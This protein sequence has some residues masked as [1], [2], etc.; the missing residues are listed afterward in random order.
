M[1]EVFMEELIYL[2]ACYGLTFTICDAKLFSRPREW[3]K[4]K[5]RLFDD[6]LTCYFCVGFWCSIVVFVVMHY[7]GLQ[8]G[9][10]WLTTAYVITYGFAGATFAYALNAVIVLMEVT[11]LPKMT[12]TG[13][14]DNLD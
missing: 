1:R 4:S 12:I 5:A 2:L 8:D 10:W 6:L 13:K 7:G 3:I 11:V 9:T 14:E